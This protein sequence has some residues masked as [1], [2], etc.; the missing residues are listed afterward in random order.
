MNT[1]VQ[2]STK[3]SSAFLNHG[4]HP[5]PGKNLAERGR[6]QRSDD[7]DKA[8][9]FGGQGETVRCVEGLSNQVYDQAVGKQ[10]SYSNKERREVVY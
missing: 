8:R 7:K 2:S 1:E 5:R 3:V 6:D 4:R 10:K 9:D